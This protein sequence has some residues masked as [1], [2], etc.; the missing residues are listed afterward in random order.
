MFLFKVMF[1]AVKHLSWKLRRW[2]IYSR[3]KIKFVIIKKVDIT[4]KIFVCVQNQQKSTI[5]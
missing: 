5:L 1:S 3:F 4:P 2:T